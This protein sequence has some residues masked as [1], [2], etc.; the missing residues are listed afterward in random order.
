MRVEHSRL[1]AWFSVVL[2][3]AVISTGLFAQRIARGDICMTK[4]DHDAVER[5]GGYRWQWRLVDGR[6]CWYYSNMVMPREELVWSYTEKDF[7][8][9]VDRVIE[10]KFYTKEELEALDMIQ[11]FGIKP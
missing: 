4:P 7:N 2:A 10:R 9:D 6:K 1:L 5:R 8:S 3:L 11:Q